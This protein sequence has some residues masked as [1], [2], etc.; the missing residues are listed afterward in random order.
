MA[1]KRDTYERF[2]RCSP[3]LCALTLTEMEVIAFKNDEE[4]DP[5]YQWYQK[6]DPTT[7]RN[8]RTPLRMHL[9][10]KL[11]V[12]GFTNHDEGDHDAVNA[13]LSGTTR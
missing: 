2:R 13:L 8:R 12:G 3:T 1:R 9:E 10:R 5:E 6:S 7:L 4:D 11:C